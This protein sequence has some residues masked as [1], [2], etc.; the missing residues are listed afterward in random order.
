MWV[1]GGLLGEIETSDTYDDAH[2]ENGIATGSVSQ[3]AN[4]SGGVIGDIHYGDRWMVYL[5]NLYWDTNATGLSTGIG[6][7]TRA[8]VTG[9]STDQMQDSAAETNLTGLDFDTSW[10]VQADDYPILRWTDPVVTTIWTSVGNN[11]LEVGESTAVTVTGQLDAGGSTNLTGE[12]TLTV[13]DPSVISIV[14]NDTVTAVGEGQA[15]VTAH[16]NNVTAYKAGVSVTLNDVESVPARYY[17]TITINGNPAPVGT[18][19][20]AYVWDDYRGSTTVTENGS[21]G[22]V[23]P[24]EEQFIVNGTE[25]DDGKTVEFYIDPP[26][27]VSLVGDMATTISGYDAGNVTEVNLTATLEPAKPPVYNL[28]IDNNGGIHTI[29]FPGPVNG[30]LD[31]IFPNGVDGITTFFSYENGSWV[32]VWDSNHTFEALDVLVVTT[33]GE[34]PATIDARIR[35]LNNMA[36][37]NATLSQGWNH[38]GAPMD[39]DAETAF[40][41]GIKD[42]LVVREVYTPAQSLEVSYWS[43]FS[44]Y[45]VGSDDWGVSP[46]S[47]SPF[48]GY[49]V[50]AT[51][52]TEIP[53]AVQNISHRQ[54][55]SSL[56]GL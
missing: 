36:A 35:L 17:G 7:A 38:V 21:Y 29:G 40:G 13:S 27:N 34:G 3:S 42:T 22:S 55:A 41:D 30:T 20:E 31:E 56:L 10:R 26:S 12:V 39:T 33:S 11:D 25:D 50:Y 37:Q 23:D 46:P 49:F 54:D 51:G 5:D 45:I 6:N 1:A 16:Y 52:E 44:N 24:F 8:E 48:G 9:L 43:G 2:I 18:V 4:L 32:Q 14:D 15:N 28:T 47:V 19:I 53:V